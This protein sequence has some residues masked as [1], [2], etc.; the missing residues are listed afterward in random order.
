MKQ[1]PPLA[2]TIQ[3]V[4]GVVR[5]VERK[6]LNGGSLLGQGLLWANSPVVSPVRLAVRRMRWTR[7]RAVRVARR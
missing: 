5:S 2:G 4:T 3:K 7:G 6:A 1:K